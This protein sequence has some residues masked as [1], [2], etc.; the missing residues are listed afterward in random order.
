MYVLVLHQTIGLV[1]ISFLL[2]GTVL[3]FAQSEELLS[4]KTSE[5]AYEEGDTIVVSGQVTSIIL[6]TPITLQIFHGGNLIDIAQITVAQDGKYTDTF[7]ATGP[8]WQSDGTY[9]VRA[10]YGT[11]VVETNF[12][13]FTK[14]TAT[15]TTNIFEVDAGSAGT[16]DVDYTIRGGTVKAMLVDSE[17]FGLIVIIDSETDGSITLELPRNSIDAT[18]SDGTDDTFLVFIDGAEVRPDETSTTSNSRTL[19][20]EFEEGDSDIEIIGTFVVPEFG[21]ITL[22]ILFFAI[23]AAIL[24]SSKKMLKIPVLTTLN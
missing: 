22:V 4:V 11:K 8:F 17:I 13:F 19:T 5:V 6:D 24:I 15:E 21:S 7:L 14:Q 18:K 2:I 16:F 3:A 1:V 10:T 20:I 12:E 9:T 23:I